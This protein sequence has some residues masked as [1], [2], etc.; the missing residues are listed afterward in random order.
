MISQ[1]GRTGLKTGCISG[2]VSVIFM[3]NRVTNLKKR[4]YFNS[5]LR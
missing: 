4:Y 3:D 2:D 5:Y 1:N